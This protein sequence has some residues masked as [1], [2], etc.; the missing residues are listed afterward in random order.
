M[1]LLLM[2]GNASFPPFV[3]NVIDIG[4]RKYVCVAFVNEEGKVSKEHGQKWKGIPLAVDYL[5]DLRQELLGDIALIS[6]GFQRYCSLVNSLYY[7]WLY[8]L[9]FS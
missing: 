6:Q 4:K 2:M 8:F 5:L 1:V 9:S 3:P 7:P